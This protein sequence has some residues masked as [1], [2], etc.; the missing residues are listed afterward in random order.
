MME[1]E[2]TPFEVMYYAIYLVFEGL[3]LRACSRAIEPFIKRSHIA[4]W[5]WMQELGSDQSFHKLFRLGRERVK[6]FAIDETEV[7][8]SI[9][10][11]FF[12]VAYE[13]FANRILGLY[14]AGNQ[15]SISVG[16]FLR[17]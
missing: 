15:N 2:R 4:V 13:P 16:L 14:F 7:R 12:F 9:E 10:S 8:G 5:N 11:A 3:S 1:R 6:I 17:D